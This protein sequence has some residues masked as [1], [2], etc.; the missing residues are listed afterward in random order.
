[1]TTTY[2]SK[3]DIN[4]L[5]AKSKL[6]IYLSNL[7]TKAYFKVT[8]S[9][10]TFMLRGQTG[11]VSINI[12]CQAFGISSQDPEIYYSVDFPKWQT[13]LQKF[14]NVNTLKLS[15]TKNLFQISSSTSADVI[16]LGVVYYKKNSNEAIIIDSFLASKRD[17]MVSSEPLCLN[18][19]IIESLNLADSLFTSQVSSSI[20]SV[21]LSAYDVM[22]ADRSVVLKILLKKALPEELFSNLKNDDHIFIHSYFIRLFDHLYKFDPHIYFSPDYS[23]I[24]WE[25]SNTALFIISE[26]RKVALPSAEEFEAIKPQDMSNSFEVLPSTLRSGLNFFTGFYE[27]S[28]W[29][30]LTFKMSK[31]QEVNLYYKHPT[32]E[33]TKLLNSTIC[34][35]EGTFA[36]DSETLR[37]ITS[38]VC[39]KFS[40][41]EA[42]ITFVFDTEAPGIYMNVPELYEVVLS[43]LEE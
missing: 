11:V 6:F 18:D 13:A 32:A 20:N 39:D 28:V 12:P 34:T 37:K 15:F 43:K 21:G 24:F 19:S 1:M 4:K 8:E 40:K 22:Y 38:K 29:K 16:N 10:F 2:L 9:T 35:S 41:D 14:E 26:D 27:G 36:V 7:F 23:T 5:Q 30:P 17:E 42:A 3:E 31:N 33:I 25:D